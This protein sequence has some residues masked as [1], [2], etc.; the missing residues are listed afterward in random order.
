GQDVSRLN[1]LNP[2]D[3]ANVEILKGPGATA[4]YGTTAAN[5]VVLITTKRGHSGKAVWH[6]YT[7]NGSF[8]DVTEYP[9]NYLAYQLLKPGAA[10]TTTAGALDATA[11]KPCYNFQAADALCAQDSVMTYNSLRDPRT[12]P[13]VTGFHHN[14]GASVAG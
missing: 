1:D 8:K 11:R 2:E 3:V 7:E 10:L 6:A 12:S 14:T 5:G 13:F 9:V 4:I